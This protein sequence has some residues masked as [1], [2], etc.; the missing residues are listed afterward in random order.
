MSNTFK[1][2]FIKRHNLDKDTELDFDILK[3]CTQVDYNDLEELHENY[4]N[5]FMAKMKM[6]QDGIIEIKHLQDIDQYIV[7]KIC[8]WLL[9][10]EDIKDGKKIRLCKN[11]HIAKKYI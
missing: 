6:H 5:E 3:I 1:N 10:L 2:Q 9:K 4:K 11:K 8:Y 7:N